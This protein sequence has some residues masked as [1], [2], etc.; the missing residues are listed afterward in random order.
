MTIWVVL[1]FFPDERLVKKDFYVPSSPTKQ[2]IIQNLG[3]I[4]IGDYEGSILDKL[5]N[6]ID[7]VICIN[8][9]LGSG[10]T[11][12][13]RYVMENYIDKVGCTECAANGH[14]LKRLTVWVDFRSLITEQKATIHD[15][16][17]TI[18]TK[19][20]DKCI[21]YL[22]DAFEFLNFWKYLLQQDE[23]GNDDF[24]EQVVG[25][26][27]TEYPEI[28]QE[29]IVNDVE[30]EKRKQVKRNIMRKNL[31]WH[32]RYL[33]LLYRYLIQTIFTG[34]R[35]C[36]IIILDNV[37]SLSTDLQR[38]LVKIIIGC[39][40]TRGPTFVILV[41]PET[42][43]RNGLNDVLR[44][45]IVHQN[46][47]PYQI[48]IDRIN[49]FLAKPEKYFQA[50]QTLTPEEKNLAIW[51]LRKIHPK[52]KNGTTYREFV[53][54]ISG[55][56]IRN[57]LVLAQS[58]FQLTI[59]EMKR[60][61][62]T[63][64]YLIRAMVRF[65]RPQYRSY[66]NSRVI[67]PFDVVGITEGRYLTKIRLLRYIAGRGGSCNTPGIISTFSMFDSLNLSQK[68][69]TVA[70]ALGE[71]LRNDCQLL[72]SNGFDAFHITPD[73]DQDEISITEIGKGYIDHLIY[74]IH[75]IQEV[76]LDSRVE[77]NFPLPQLYA[78]KLTEKIS[79][80]VKFLE[81][82]YQTEVDEVHIF[83]EKGIVDYAKIFQPRLISLDIISKTYNN[84]EKLLL[85]RKLRKRKN[86]AQ[87]YEDVLNEFKELK[88]QVIAT[89]NRLFG[90][91]DGIKPEPE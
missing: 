22:D 29:Q 53:K 42:F 46:P 5:I 20:W 32:L 43:E 48:V 45:I 30:I 47:D 75:F 49:R 36:A 63:A 77:A 15:L 16:L 76:M 52:L 11:T 73:D 33:I 37:D 50:A 7:P 21:Y 90:V 54:N 78:D 18:C 74:N 38:S 69:D 81:K 44:D 70:V 71:L 66:Q 80:M 13:M 85:S 40:H 84:T 57:A 67:N 35:E 26:I 64:Q 39:S 60:R 56:N 1:F 62:L 55:R 89:N 51:Y 28:R 68:Y 6:P 19:L 27:H 10:K 12:T 14:P 24:V 72:T 8:G 61:D 34:N 91:S 4:E 58:V 88:Y 17:E 87:E 82:V 41:R 2:V 9:R 31:I 3:E 83:R 79:V 59:G 23:Q 25:I 86:I 65:G